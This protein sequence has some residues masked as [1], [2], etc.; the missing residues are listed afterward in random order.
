MIDIPVNQIT[1]LVISTAKEEL[2]PRFAQVVR[3]EKADGS[4]ITE[5]DLAA[6][7]RIANGLAELSPEIAFLGEEMTVEEQREQISSGAT[8]WC[9][10]PLDGTSNFTAGIPYFSVSLALI[11]Q[12]QVVFGL[13]YDPMRDECFLASAD[14][15]PTLNNAPI[16]R[17]EAP[18][19]LKKAIAL[20]DYKRLPP[21]LATRLVVEIPYSSQRSFGSVA[22]DWCWL[23]AG[24]SH[25]YLHGKQNIWDY[26]AG[27]FIF[28][29]VGGQ[30]C[31]LDNE[32]VFT[33]ALLPRSALGAL[34]PD[35]FTQW[36][37]WLLKKS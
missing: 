33:H 31:T 4:I 29:R 5:A 2:L 35:L 37:D 13:V 24:R 7:Q 21:D 12:G 8:L 23:A 9:L 32:P 22:L 26:A 10:D 20:I 30:S 6:Q 25:L 34:S 15:E 19:M 27:N 16:P 17:T 1:Q 28:S 36:R 11:D 18:S 3:Q 14:Q